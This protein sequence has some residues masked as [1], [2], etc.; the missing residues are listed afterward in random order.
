VDGLGEAGGV[1]SVGEA[2]AG[3]LG[4]VEL[5]LVPAR[6]PAQPARRTRPRNTA[7]GRPRCPVR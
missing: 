2:L 7:S 1:V 4:P 6:G 5:G 3:V